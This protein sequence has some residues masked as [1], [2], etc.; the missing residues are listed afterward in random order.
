MRASSTER[1]LAS[2]SRR[3]ILPEM[4]TQPASVPVSARETEQDVEEEEESPKRTSETAAQQQR[5]DKIQATTN[6]VNASQVLDGEFAD[7]LEEDEER[8]EMATLAQQRKHE[9]C[10]ISKDLLQLERGSSS[11]ENSLRVFQSKAAPSST[12]QEETCARVMPPLP[13]S[14]VLGRVKSFLPVLDKANRNL[15]SDIQERGAEQFDIEVVN[16]GDDKPYI[17]MDLALGFA[18][19]YTPE[20][21]AAAELAA[22]GQLQ[23]R[24]IPIG[25]AENS[26]ESESDSDSDSDEEQETLENALSTRDFRTSSATVEMTS[27][28]RVSKRSKIQPM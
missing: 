17:Q 3:R 4:E 21:V 2:L 22:N 13:E 18:D 15:F 8:G 11:L 20:A 12:W 1:F 9:P 24:E 5:R 19:L 26:S 25:L 6:R 14:S 23:Q 16:V 7:P 28:D 10:T 27:N